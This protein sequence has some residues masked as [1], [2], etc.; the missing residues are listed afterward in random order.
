MIQ[1]KDGSGSK[2]RSEDVR[3]ASTA[4][5][6]ELVDVLC[7]VILRTHVGITVSVAGRRRHIPIR[8]VQGEQ[9]MG[10]GQVMLTLPGHLVRSLDLLGQCL[11][12]HDVAD[13]LGRSVD[14]IYRNINRLILTLDFP[15]PILPTGQ[16]LW[17]PSSVD[18]WLRRY[19]PDA[20]RAPP[21]P[22]D[23][24]EA[25]RR[26]LHKAAGKVEP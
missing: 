23:P 10:A 8:A 4:A 13:R 2:E 22:D 11:T 19:H 5:T 12:M 6:T 26:A 18:A 24:I 14:W 21:V 16:K 9:D 1:R 25:S 3:P 15:R 7:T 17:D 20:G